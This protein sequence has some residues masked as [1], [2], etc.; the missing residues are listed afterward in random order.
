VLH[1]LH[2]T[3]L[4][5]IDDLDLELHPGLNVLTGETG[6]GKTMVAVGLSL[7]LGR[8]ASATLVRD[9]ARAAQVQARFDAPASA[10]GWAEDG[11]LLLARTVG[12]DGK[13]SAR[14]G[15]QLASVSTLAALGEGLV[16]VHGQHRGQRLLSAAAQTEFVDRFAGPTHL[17][18]LDSFRRA[19]ERL[20]EARARLGELAALARDREREIDLLGYQVREIETTAPEPGEMAELEAEGSR[21]SN[22]ERLLERTASAAEAL[23][24]DDAGVDA[25]RAA[26]ASLM[27]VGE[28]DDAVEELAKRS[29]S[30]AEEGSE[31]AHDVRAYRES[32]SLDPARL[33]DIRDR[34]QAL[35]TLRRKYGETEVEVLAYLEGTLA[36]LASLTGAEDR[37]RELETETASLE[38][39]A[40]QLTAAVSAGRAEVA[41]RLRIALAR[42]LME[43][44]MEGATIEVALAPLP[45]PTANGSE[46]AEF[47]FSGG[48]GQPSL[49]L[50][51]VASGG[52]VSRMMLAC[53]SVLV[54]LDD[55]PT[56]VFDEVD[57]G[58][59]GRAAAAVGRRL[60][61]LARTRQVLVVTHLPQIASFADRHIRVEKS[62]GRAVVEVLTEGGR[63]AEL[64]RMLSGL[65]ESE[66]SATHAEELL[67][68]AGRVKAR[69]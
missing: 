56:L 33:A 42:E 25:L 23:S 10:E 36:R 34:I 24:G 14:V 35:R 8:R 67:A 28:A 46:R 61:R 4:G 20:R 63:V 32:V 50:S 6:A 38:E 54:D 29:A 16:E 44:G 13:T 15:G 66:T 39:E 31:L 58:I 51:K 48:P 68:E 3:G 30:L 22:A 55:V 57:A 40:A 52:E 18:R 1:E 37:R 49:P 21:L 27:E 2:I 47:L 7:A 65:P 41:P 9:G 45:E 60:A 53:R 11:G 59:G 5:V 12:A 69:G 17:K 64:S 62:G 43:L 19:H 26:A